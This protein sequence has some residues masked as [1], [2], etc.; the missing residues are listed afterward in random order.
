MGSAIGQV[1]LI[2]KATLQLKQ[3]NKK[4]FSNAEELCCYKDLK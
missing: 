2:K 4:F 3:T 1:Q